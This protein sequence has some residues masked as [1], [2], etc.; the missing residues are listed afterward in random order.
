MSL[1]VKRGFINKMKFGEV[2]VGEQ[3]ETLGN[4]ES[5]LG[6]MLAQK[7]ESGKVNAFRAKQI[8]SQNGEEQWK[9]RLE[10]I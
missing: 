6:R 5:F 9:V 8:I 2:L 1:V 10:G 3:N 7:W 4:R